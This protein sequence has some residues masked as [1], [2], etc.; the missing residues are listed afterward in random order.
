MVCC[1]WIAQER[2]GKHAIHPLNNMDGCIL[3]WD[4]SFFSVSSSFYSVF[5]EVSLLGDILSQ[6]V[7]RDGRMDI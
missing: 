5:E 3:E 1:S 6:R 2:R 7:K 4:V